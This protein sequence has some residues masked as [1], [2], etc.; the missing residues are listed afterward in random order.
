[1]QV[2]CTQSLY[3]QTVPCGKESPPFVTVHGSLSAVTHAA[4]HASVPACLTGWPNA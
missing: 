4:F 2:G 1:M 3:C